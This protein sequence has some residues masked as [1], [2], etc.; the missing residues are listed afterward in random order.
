M[1][2]YRNNT[3]NQRTFLKTMAM[4]HVALVAG[5]V[6]FAIAVI[7]INNNKAPFSFSVS[8]S[9]VFMMIVP[10]MGIGAF[11]VGRF[12]FAKVLESAKTKTTLVEKLSVYQSATL[13]RFAFCQGASLFAIVITM[14]TSNIF[15]LAISAILVLYMIFLKPSCDRI[16]SDLN[17]TF[18]E[19]AELG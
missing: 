17:L 9:D 6:L 16:E 8:G 4:I 3:I 12:V 18:E 5:Q 10:L 11:A 19:Q 1:P 15:Y 2:T 14:I 13:I 7:A